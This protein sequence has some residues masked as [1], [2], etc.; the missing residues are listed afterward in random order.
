M[1]GHQWQA[2]PAQVYTNNNNQLQ[3]NPPQT[4][5]QQ[6][7]SEQLQQPIAQRLLDS[8]KMARTESSEQKNRDHQQRK[9][10][11]RERSK[12]KVPQIRYTLSPP[13]WEDRE[14]GKRRGKGVGAEAGSFPPPQ[15][16]VRQAR[17]ARERPQSSFEPAASASASRAAAAGGGGAGGSSAPPTWVGLSSGPAGRSDSGGGAQAGARDPD[18]KKQDILQELDQINEQLQQLTSEEESS[19]ERT[20]MNQRAAA[21]EELTQFMSQ[22]ERNQAS[23]QGGGRGEAV[24]QNSSGPA[25]ETPPTKIVKAGPQDSIKVP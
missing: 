22:A 6:H 1:L 24:G 17:R 9:G 16:F 2:Q 15:R 8:T 14:A 21:L 3:R 5:Q 10:S 7:Y 20:K 4:S 25:G 13:P 18:A 12:K 19:E 11:P 23:A